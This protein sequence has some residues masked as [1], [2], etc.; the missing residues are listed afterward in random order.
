MRWD[1]PSLAPMVLMISVSGSSSTLNRRAYSEATAAR[2]L[3]IPRLL[4]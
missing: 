1:R 2:S 4:E 3:G